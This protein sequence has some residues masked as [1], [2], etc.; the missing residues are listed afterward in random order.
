M[1]QARVQTVLRLKPEL[2]EK[3]KRKARKEKRSFNSYVEHLLE[4]EAGIKYPVLPADFTVSEE[5][6]SM[7]CIP[8]RAPEP[9][10]L[11]SDPK[12]AYL[13]GKYGT[14]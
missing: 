11:A 7:A 14:V 10:Q 6:A 3:I 12:L 5:I 4:K 13:W 2:M 8:W 1:E 9:E